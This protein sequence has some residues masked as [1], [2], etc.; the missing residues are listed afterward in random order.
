MRTRTPRR[1][2]RA[3]LLQLLC[4]AA[5]LG[6]G[7]LLP[8]ITTGPSVASTRVA[9]SLVAVGFGILGLTS[10][11]YS[12]LSWSRSGRSAACRPG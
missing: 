4:V 12:L 5:G 3:G 2:L 1:R 10:L 11:I 9:E 6:L 8:Q 7:L